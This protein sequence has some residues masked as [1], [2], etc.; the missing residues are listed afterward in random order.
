MKA[1]VADVAAR[2]LGHHAC[3]WLECSCYYR[4]CSHRACREQSPAPGWVCCPRCAISHFAGTARFALEIL[5]TLCF[6]FLRSQRTQAFFAAPA[7][8]Q[9][10]ASITGTPHPLLRPCGRRL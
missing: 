4:G 7:D 10:E 2:A 6:G 9:E 1:G 8:R 3:C 5:S